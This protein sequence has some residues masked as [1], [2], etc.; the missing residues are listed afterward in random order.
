MVDVSVAI[1]F[2]NKPLQTIECL[3]SL[4]A[5]VSVYLL[6]NGSDPEATKTVEQYLKTREK[7]D[8][9]ARYTKLPKNMG[10]SVG[11]N[12]LIRQINDGWVVF[13]DNDITI[14]QPNWRNLLELA[15]E[16]YPEA[17]AFAPRLHNKH[18]NITL[19][20][21]NLLPEGNVIKVRIAE[22][23]YSNI[24]R[25]GAVIAH[26][27]L[28]DIVG[29]YDE[30]FIACLEDNEL[31][32]RAWKTG[33]PF[34][35]YHLPAITLIHEH[36]KSDKAYDNQ[37]LGV[38]YGDETL[39]NSL[40]RIKDLY[41]LVPDHDPTNWC[42]AQIRTMQG[43]TNEPQPEKQEVKEG[44]TRVLL[45]AV[46]QFRIG[47]IETFNANFCKR[48]SKYYDVT[49][50]CEKGDA[51]RLKEMAKHCR[52]VINQGQ[53]IETDVAVYTTAW[54]KRPDGQIKAKRYIQMIHADYDWLNKAV[55]N[56]KYEK[57]PWVG[58]AGHV[59]VG[60]N[61]QRQFERLTGFTGVVI[62]NLLDPDTKTRKV[63]RLI[64][65]TRIAREKGFARMVKLA[66]TL[67]DNGIPFIWHIYGD[68]E[69]TYETSIRQMFS[70]H[71]NVIFMGV[72]YEP[73][74][75][76][77][78]ADYLVSFSDSEGFSYSTYEALQVGTPCLCTNYPSATEQVTNGVNGYIFDMQLSNL[79]V[80]KIYT[81]IP[82]GFK[83]KEK[84]T[85]KAWCDLIGNPAPKG[86]KSGA[87]LETALTQEVTAQVL[88][89][90]TDVL[91]QKK[92]IAGTMEKY[93]YF[94]ATELAN[95]GIIK[96][97]TT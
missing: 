28:F 34:K 87:G 43:N 5:G 12:T 31:T 64:S 66:D 86:F 27:R 60:E 72:S 46:N 54:G 68:G 59:C 50:M 89:T 41:N 8:F 90:Y 18:E 94:R 19:D 1:I 58:N 3:E 65:V 93:S 2:Y 56:W 57:L 15:I 25:G 42:K 48:M 80:E 70:K 63:L 53:T 51:D 37:Y 83:F 79:D 85:E 23:E 84:G 78:D 11:R 67:R 77:A 71:T 75:Y 52:V 96:I 32:I 9:I 16:R 88:K 74:D 61:V 76:V 69:K 92:L 33:R 82:K 30:N 13:L 6:N 49:F 39:Q 91:L 95:K 10:A 7:D 21:Y 29:M 24:I 47:G 26:R 35:V 97:I 17:M 36:R 73:L 45:V 44:I 55:G 40:K 20:Y 4:G 81:K 14:K 38:R 62:P 22:G